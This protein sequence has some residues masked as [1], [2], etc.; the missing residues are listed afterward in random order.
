MIYLSNIWIDAL[1]FE[2]YGGFKSET[3]FVRSVGMGY[4]IASDIPGEPVKNATTTF[5]VKKEGMYRFFVRTKNWKLPEAPGQFKVI[6]DGNEFEHICGKMPNTDWYWE[7]AGDFKLKVGTHT[8]EIMDTTGWL[9]RFSAIFITDDMDITPSPETQVFKKLRADCKGINLNIKGRKP[10]DFVVVGAGPGGVG[11][12]ISA[13]RNGLKVALISG[14][15]TVGGNASDEGTI[16]LDGASSHHF[17][18]HETGIANDIKATKEHFDTTAQKSIEILLSG[19]KN[20]SVFCDELCINATTKNNKILN[21]TTI[22]TKTLQKYKYTAKFFADCSG[23]GWL[24]YYAGA[25][26]RIGREANWQH[27]EEHAPASPDTFTMSGCICDNR[28]N[29]PK[30]RT[31]RAIDTGAP[32]SFETPSWAIQF[33]EKRIPKREP[34]GYS[35]AAWWIENSNDFDDIWNDEFVR[36]EMVRVGVGYFGWIKNVYEN[37]EQ[38]ANYKLVAMALHNSKRESRRLIGDYVFNENDYVEGKTFPDAVSYCGWNMDVHHPKG[39][40]SGEDGPFL[41]NKKVP[42]T[43]IPYRTLYS[44]NTQNLFMAGRCCSV[45]HLGLGSVRV[46][47]TIVTLGQVV[48][49]AAMICIKYGITP[50]EIYNSKINELQQTLIRQGMTIPN[51]QAR[52]PDDLAPLCKIEATSFKENFVQPLTYGYLGKWIEIKEEHFCGPDWLDQKAGAEYYKVLIKNTDKKQKIT[53]R[54]YGGWFPPFELKE[55]KIITIEEN[56]EGWLSLPFRPTKEE[57]PFR[58]SLTPEN[59]IFWREIEKSNYMLKHL[60]YDKNGELSDTGLNAL[61]LDFHSKNTLITNGE[62]Q[63]TTNGFTRWNSTDC[64]CWISDENKS[65]PQ[66][67]TYTLPKTTEISSVEITTDTDLIN[68]RVAFWKPANDTDQVAFTA[69]DV[70]LLIFDGEKWKKVSSKKDNYLRQIIFNFKSQ[71]AQKVKI[72]VN[73]TTGNK[74]VKIYEVRIYK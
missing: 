28:P 10:F 42:I 41:I 73:S 48:G 55:E 66:S 62:P 43:P 30:I 67:I 14:R 6:I 39:V 72:Q 35:S 12:A 26:Y 59:L 4:L 16:N 70:D 17:G 71:K 60:R 13:A 44:K 50:R 54:L 29:M 57:I 47:A 5:Y 56:F 21:I 1:E 49:T 63:K 18:M 3:Q 51:I 37:K 53:A 58:I 15:P 64:N 36:D 20:I 52:D 7:I 24:G 68:P 11:A 9:G 8:I 40:Y 32:V 65:F 34:S 61:A 46:E 74:S 25:A 31:F 2:N 19:E 45:S 22:N 27:N 33:T 38:A 23:D 69:K